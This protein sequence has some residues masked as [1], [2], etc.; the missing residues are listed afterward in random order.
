M[1]FQVHTF[2][3]LRC[4]TMGANKYEPVFVSPFRLLWPLYFAG[5]GGNESLYLYKCDPI[6]VINCEFSVLARLTGVCSGEQNV[7]ECKLETSFLRCDEAAAFLVL[8]LFIQT[9]NME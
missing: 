8:S 9:G 3:P 4:L 2:V 7:N 5:G 1:T 6:P